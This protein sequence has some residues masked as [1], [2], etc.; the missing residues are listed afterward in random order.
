MRAD[1]LFELKE[2]TVGLRRQLREVHTQRLDHPASPSIF[3]EKAANM[4]SLRTAVKR[5]SR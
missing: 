1:R 4:W 3:I 5:A 2:M